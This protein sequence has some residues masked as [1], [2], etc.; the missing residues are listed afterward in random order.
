MAR[1]SPAMG[2]D[3]RPFGCA[4]TPFV[5]RGQLRVPFAKGDAAGGDMGS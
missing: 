2:S 5:I 3:L 4:A 1:H